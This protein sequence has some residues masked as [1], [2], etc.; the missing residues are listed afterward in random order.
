LSSKYPFKENGNNEDDEAQNE[1]EKEYDR[2]DSDD[3]LIKMDEE[4]LN[5]SK[6]NKKKMKIS[7][8]ESS[9]DLINLAGPIKVEIDLTADLAN[10]LNQKAVPKSFKIE[11]EIPQQLNT[12]KEAFVRVKCEKEIE[13][14]KE[15]PMIKGE[16]I[17]NHNSS[18]EINGGFGGNIPLNLQMNNNM[19][20]N[21]FNHGNNGSFGGNNLAMMQAFQESYLKSMQNFM[22][23][24]I[25]IFNMIENQY[26]NQF[27]YQDY[28]KQYMENI[29]KLYE[30]GLKK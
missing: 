7:K 13:K 11:H 29:K 26:A 23:P 6:N 25:N 3:T 28:M 19:F 24:Q 5:Y 16:E 27:I 22:T 17:N 14:K 21:T 12:L 10:K 2:S 8:K 9:E 30:N 15:I 20:Q 4:I 1:D 18:I